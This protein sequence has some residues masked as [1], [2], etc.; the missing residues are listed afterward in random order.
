MRALIVDDSASMRM[1]LNKL[2]KDLGIESSQANDGQQALDVLLQGEKFDFA[3]VDWQM[4]VMDGI[5]FVKSVRG[6][7]KYNLM[8]L[9]MVTSVNQIESIVEALEAGA[10][11]YIMKPFTKEALAEK[12]VL[13]GIPI[14]E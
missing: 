5:E 12:L 2:L 1:L 13:I 4:P 10:D 3:L 6:C 8:K 7:D 11:E 14:S 9:L